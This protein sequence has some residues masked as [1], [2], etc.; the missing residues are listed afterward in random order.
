MFCNL[1]NVNKNF[2]FIPC[3]NG[4]IC[5]NCLSKTFESNIQDIIFKPINM[6]L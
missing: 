6:V 2:E 4:V 3:C 1:Y 5:E